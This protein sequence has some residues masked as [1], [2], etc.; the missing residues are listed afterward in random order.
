[1]VYSSFFLSH[2]ALSRPLPFPVPFFKR[3]ICIYVPHAKAKVTLDDRPRGKP[4]CPLSDGGKSITSTI[5]KHERAIE[6]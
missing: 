2:K 3:S 1:M 6:A 5:I 4:A